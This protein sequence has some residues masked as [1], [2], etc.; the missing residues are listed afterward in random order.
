MSAR[1]CT[2]VALLVIAACALAVVPDAGATA[3]IDEHYAALG[4]PSGFLGAPVGPERSSPGNGHYRNYRGGAIY[5]TSHTGAHEIHGSIRNFWAKLDPFETHVTVTKLGYPQ[6]DETGVDLAGGLIGRYNDFEGGSLFYRPDQHRTF[7]TYRCQDTWAPCAVRVCGPYNCVKTRP[8][9]HCDPD[10]VVSRLN[11][12]PEP[13][14]SAADEALGELTT[15]LKKVTGLKAWRST[16]CIVHGA[17]GRPVRPAQY[18]TDG[19]Y[20]LDVKL[21]RFR[22]GKHLIAEGNNQYL[23]LEIRPDHRTAH[24]L[25]A[26][27]RPGPGDLVVFG[28]LLVRDHTLH[29][30]VKP[31]NIVLRDE[32]GFLEVHPD[33]EFNVVPEAPPLAPPVRPSAPAPPP[34]PAFIQDTTL[35]AKCPGGLAPGTGANVNGTIAPV[36]GGAP[37]DV[38][39]RRPDGSTVLVRTVTGGSGDYNAATVA[40]QPGS[41]QVSAHYAGDGSHRESSAS[42]AFPVTDGSDPR[43]PHALSLTCANANAG[44]PVA[45]SGVLN[46]S[47]PGRSI[48]LA[49]YHNDSS[50]PA[51]TQRVD[52]NT[53]GSYSFTFPSWPDDFGQWKAIARYGA[54]EHNQAAES[55]PCQFF[56]T[57]PPH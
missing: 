56:I 29:V 36:I 30:K 5:W 21:L 41:W 35:T 40:D 33:G 51:R 7:A 39:F 49:F 9:T 6:T 20:T 45:F 1:H 3:A 26:T 46:P 38:T 24:A 18:S 28:G 31:F 34:Q 4:G 12:A 23:R 42:C 54:D 53:D 15:P 52:L 44:T 43:E 10:L 25:T 27:H 8:V 55:A 14:L 57:P 48:E 50:T 2:V 32:Y 22:L 47:D 37:V 19:F 11:D 13:K 16:R 17:I